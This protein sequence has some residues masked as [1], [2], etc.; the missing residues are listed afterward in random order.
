MR[1]AYTGYAEVLEHLVPDSMDCLVSKVLT[2]SDAKEHRI[3]LP[4][5]RCEEMLVAENRACNSSSARDVILRIWIGSE[6]LFDETLA[7]SASRAAPPAVAPCSVLYRAARA[8]APAQPDA[9]PAAADASGLIAPSFWTF[10]YRISP[11]G[12]SF[13]H[14][15]HDQQGVLASLGVRE[16][17]RV[18]LCRWKALD[19]RLALLVS[20]PPKRLHRLAGASAVG[21]A[22]HHAAAGAQVLA[23]PSHVHGGRRGHKRRR[24]APNVYA[25]NGLPPIG[26]N[27]LP[28]PQQSPPPKRALKLFPNARIRVGNAFQAAI[29]PAL[30]AA[31]AGGAPAEPG[32][33]GEGAG[34]RAEPVQE[35]A[36]ATR[37]LLG[38]DSSSPF[39]AWTEAEHERFGLALSSHGKDMP[40]IAR[41]MGLRTQEAVEYYYYRKAHA[42]V[43]DGPVPSF[44]MEPGPF[45]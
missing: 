7:P 40:L 28:W 6:S 3:V 15:M 4:K 32:G 23:S 26:A 2:T 43:L 41:A 5:G 36:G 19:R 29:P 14:T 25:P 20:H 9:A 30:E 1:G 33:H 45:L 44:V 24:L 42:Y 39:A 16:G 17:D 35:T 31:G 18:M 37:A 34:A 11:C 8:E 13:I 22:S 27:R 12:K 38:A 21:A 10:R